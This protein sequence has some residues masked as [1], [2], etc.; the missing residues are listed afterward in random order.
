MQ[1][2]F[3]EDKEATEAIKWMK[4]FARKM[5]TPRKRGFSCISIFMKT[6]IYYNKKDGSYFSFQPKRE[7]PLLI[8]SKG[9]VRAS[10]DFG[11][12]PYFKKLLKT[13]IPIEM[14]KARLAKLLLEGVDWRCLID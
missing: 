7:I 13:S 3:M 4:D 6:K 1:D 14:D 8:L 5:I 2:N 11:G 10:A 12:K 9:A